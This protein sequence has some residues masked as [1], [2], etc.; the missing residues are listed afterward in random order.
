MESVDAVGIVFFAEYWVW[1]ERLFED[2]VA[3]ASGQSW[4][5]I[6]ESG[7]AIPVVHAEIDYQRPLYLSD[8]VTAELS[9]TH[10]GNRSLQFEAS[11]LTES[12]EVA[13]L[14]RTVNVVA[15]PGK[16]DQT[17]MPDWLEALRLQE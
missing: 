12:G 7:L 8:K 4:R 13:A 16:L 1:F 11:F 6:V 15:S 14:A 10:V 2:F 5:E 17:V 3:K 9:L